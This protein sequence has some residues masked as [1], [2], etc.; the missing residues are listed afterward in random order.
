M[1]QTGPLLPDQPKP[2]AWQL[3]LSTA[4][5]LML[6]TGTLIGLNCVPMIH[7]EERSYGWP[8]PVLNYLG[9]LPATL[10][11]GW[12]L[13]FDIVSNLLIVVNAG[14]LWEVLMWRRARRGR[15]WKSHVISLFSAALATLIVC[16][17]NFYPRPPQTPVTGK[18]YGWPLVT[19][20][21]IAFEYVGPVSEWLNIHRDQRDLI[22]RELG[23]KPESSVGIDA[24]TQTVHVS[25][26]PGAETD[27]GG[28]AARV[29]QVT[30]LLL[31]MSAWLAAEWFASRQHSAKERMN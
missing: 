15:G 18:L 11:S 8:I 25:M 3:H 14:V 20:R 22:E 6:V 7:P 10:R 13:W 1:A 2:R 24:A 17:L 27:L 21:D 28:I 16:F 4:I 5:V 12:P 26:K 31:I 9:E 23:A 19:R 29:N 30:A